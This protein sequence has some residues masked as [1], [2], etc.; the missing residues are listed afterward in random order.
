MLIQQTAIHGLFSIAL[1]PHVD[2]RGFFARLYC[3]EEFSRAGISFASTQINLSRNTAALTL[4]GLHYQTEPYAEA[5]IVRC[6]RGRIFDV[7]VDLR[8]DSPTYRRWSGHELDAQTGGALF[9]PEGCAHG[10]LTLTAD[11]DVLYQMGR[12]FEPGHAAGVRWDDPAIAIHWPAQ[13]CVISE[14]DRTWP[15]LA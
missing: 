10:F 4:R 15:L 12:M 8:P 6:T 11:T 2:E 9:I 13:P 3:P 7:A 14:A 5:K 1:A